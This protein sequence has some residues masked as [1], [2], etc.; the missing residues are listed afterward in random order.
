MASF[1][2]I[3]AAGRGYSKVWEEKTYLY[4]LAVIP[5]VI[6]FVCY[7]T[8][9]ALDWEE[10]F[11]RQALVMLPSYFADGWMLSHFV[12][13]IFLDQRWPFKPSGDPEKDMANVNMGDN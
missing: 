10:N 3:D 5:V 7:L 2:I 12:R 11:I 13:L 4:Q 6:K 1:D 9:Q 8:I